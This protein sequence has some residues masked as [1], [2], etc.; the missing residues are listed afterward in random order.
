[1]EWLRSVLT[2]RWQLREY[3]LSL[4]DFWVCLSNPLIYSYS[5]FLASTRGSINSSDIPHDLQG[6]LDWFLIYLDRTE[7]PDQEPPFVAVYA[8]KAFLVAFQLLRGGI[9]DA[10]T[11]VG[12]ADGDIEAALEWAEEMFRRREKWMVGGLILQNLRSLGES[13]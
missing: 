4:I 6:H 5:S 12:V 8:Y 3:C 11:A 10:M 9:P 7:Q 13:L 2:R 1:M